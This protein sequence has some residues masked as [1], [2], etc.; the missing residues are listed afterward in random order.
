MI[1][2]PVLFLIVGRQ[3]WLASSLACDIVIAA[4]MV[5]CVRPLNPSSW[6]TLTFHDTALK[7][8]TKSVTQSGGRTYH[9]T[10]K[11]RC[12]VG[13]TDCSLCRG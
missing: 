1:S 7:I 10:Y 11:L 9:P 3:L 12:S 5:Y 2:F 4:S 8:E 6:S 13:H